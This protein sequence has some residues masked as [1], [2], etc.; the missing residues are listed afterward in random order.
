MNV[1]EIIDDMY[2]NMLK[3]CGISNSAESAVKDKFDDTHKNL[4]EEPKMSSE[5]NSEQS[6]YGSGIKFERLRR[7]TGYISARGIDYM[8]NAK[9]SEVK[10]RVKHNV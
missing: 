4:L 7:V 8:N 10:D 3:R 6:G 9:Q 2:N 5:T 1:D